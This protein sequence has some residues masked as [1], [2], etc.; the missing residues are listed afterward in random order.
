MKHHAAI[1]F[2]LDGTLVTSSL[3]FIAIRQEI[4]CPPEQDA[5]AF[6]AALPSPEAQH[7]AMAVIHRH[8][9]EDARH[10][11]WMPGAK[12]FIEH[13][14]KAGLLLGIVTRNSLPSTRSKLD[15]NA[16]PIHHI[17]TRESSAP[18]P[19][20]DA[21]LE[22]A[23]EFELDPQDVLMV[24][25]Y[26]YDLEA[27]HNAGMSACLINDAATPDFDHLAHYR[28]RNFTEMQWQMFSA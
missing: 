7:Q 26:R 15:N 8:E 16:I 13:C 24:G 1:I 2:D 21:L 12:A 28:F 11:Q 27:A 9:A 17:R 23:R 4:G 22:L 25:D 3:N 19:Q 6:I 14:R 18:K 20:P 10:S 5:L